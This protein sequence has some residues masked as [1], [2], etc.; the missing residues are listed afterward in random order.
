VGLLSA[1][2]GATERA[3]A[4]PGVAFSGDGASIAVLLA[5]PDRRPVRLEF[6]D[7]TSGEATARQALPAVDAGASSHLEVASRGAFALWSAGER[8]F[9]IGPEE[10][11]KELGIELSASG[12]FRLAPSDDRVAFVRDG[13]LLVAG[14]DGS[15]PVAMPEGERPGT[16]FDA[17]DGSFAWSP[18]GRFL[19]FAARDAKGRR[20]VAVTQLLDPFPRLLET[21]SEAAPDAYGFRWRYDVRGLAVARRNLEAGRDE[22]LLC[23]AEKLY[24]RDLATRSTIERFDRLQDFAFVDDGFLWGVPTEN[25]I[26]LAIFD[27]LGRERRRLLPPLLDLDRVEAVYSDGATI[28][29]GARLAGHPDPPVALFRTDRVGTEPRGLT[30][31]QAASGA[32]APLVPVWVL[33]RVHAGVVTERMLLHVGGG[34]P[35]ELGVQAADE[36]P[37]DAGGR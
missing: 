5:G 19:A 36:A 27:T 18:D 20:R 29:L 33:S 21:P 16:R 26:D 31:E 3:P 32:F 25:R 11:A 10:G 7:T 37:A 12:R 2:A 6:H 1:I 13:E 35:A 23:H 22:L 4:D 15:A 28:V 9:R 17:A 34:P 30:P 24:C 14:L 8:L